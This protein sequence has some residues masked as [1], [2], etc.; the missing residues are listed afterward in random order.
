VQ[1]KR[2]YSV[3][4]KGFKNLSGQTWKTVLVDFDPVEDFL[5]DLEVCLVLDDTNCSPV[6]VMPY[7]GSMIVQED[8]S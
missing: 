5:K 3:N 2:D 4:G 1:L 8:R 7:Y 6:S